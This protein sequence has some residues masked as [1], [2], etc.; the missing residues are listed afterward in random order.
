[1]RVF[2]YNVQLPVLNFSRF[3]KE[4]KE[5]AVFDRFRQ[6]QGIPVGQLAREL[7]G[8]QDTV[9]VKP[10]VAAM[11]RDRRGYD[12]IPNQNDGIAWDR[13]QINDGLG[14]GFV[15]GGQ[16]PVAGFQLF[17]QCRIV[18]PE[19]FKFLYRQFKRLH[20]GGV[21]RIP[22]P[23]RFNVGQQRFRV[24]PVFIPFGGQPVNGPVRPYNRN[25]RRNNNDGQ[26]G[27]FNPRFH[28]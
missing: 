24:V 23:V 5:P 3:P 13:P 28:Y 4:A 15:D 27:K 12:G 16:I 1:M 22:D 9:K 17:Y 7:V 26:D 11:D 19:P 25:G 10:R 18:G 14:L 8:R 21:Q 20:P 6:Q 2:A